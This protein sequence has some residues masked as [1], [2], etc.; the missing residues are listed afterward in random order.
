LSL[1]LLLAALPVLYWERPPDTAPALRQAGIEQVRV[2]PGRTREWTTAGLE[3][4]PL[5]EAEKSERVTLKTPGLAGRADLGSATRRPWLD[6]NGWRFLRAPKARYFETAAKDGAVL[7]AAEA[8]AYGADLVLA[9][10]PADLQALGEALRFLRSV[11][12]LELPDLADIGVV[13][14]GSPITGE[15]MNLLA[16]RNLLFRPVAHGA[17]ELPVVVEIGTPAYPQAEAANPDAF[18]LKIRGELG[19]ERRTLRLYGSEVVLARLVGDAS[20]LRLHLLNYSGRVV[21]GVRVRLRG[22]WTPG[23]ALLLPQGKAAVEAPLVQDG[24]TEFSLP[25]L[26]PYAIVELTAAR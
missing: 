17:P 24:A 9:I 22:L 16:R 21:Q 4:I 6:T 1:A 7:A 3:A 25:G 8:F 18:A 2:R 12:A 20:R 14:D 11:P 13:D 10:E 23:D 15:V 19:D 5:P 26:G